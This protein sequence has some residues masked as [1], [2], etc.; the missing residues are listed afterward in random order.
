MFLG[1]AFLILF[2]SVG[3]MQPV[4]AAPAGQAVSGGLVV[5]GAIL[6]LPATPGMV[7]VH[8]MTVGTGNTA[9]A[10]DVTVEAGGF[11][12]D[13]DGSFQEIPPAQDHNPF[14]ALSYIT[15]ISKTSFHLNPG[16]TTEVDVTITLPADPGTKTRYATIYVKGTPIGSSSVTQVLAV[17]VPIIIT[18]QGV[19]FSLTGKITNLTVEPVQP[20]EP[21][22]VD[23][24]VN[25]TGTR[26]FKVQGD[27]TITDPNGQ[28]VTDIKLPLT[29]NSIVPPYS[30]ILTGKYSALDN[31]NGLA[32]GT[33][34]VVVKVT[35]DDGTLVDTAQ[36]TFVIKEPLLICPGVDPS[37]M[38]VQTFT[39]Q[40]PGTVDARNQTNVEV[41]FQNTGPVTGA[42]AI[43]EYSQEPDG[44]PRF[45]DTAE[46]GGT[47]GTGVRFVLIRENGIDQ[48]N[49]QVGISYQQGEL[50]ALDPNS[51]FLATRLGSSWVKLGGLTV[52]TGAQMVTGNLSVDILKN[53]TLIALGGGG[54]GGAG[55]PLWAYG[56]IGLV[57]ALLILLVIL[58]VMSRRRPKEASGS[59]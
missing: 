5:G 4:S 58:L 16:D 33:Y 23:T 48:G 27:V 15:N 59:R 26:H 20:G 19:Q 38:V 47:G 22:V 55:L 14:S 17:L 3:P 52:Q 36:T 13:T 21:I 46:N 2:V 49:A 30:Q 6:D 35:R 43:C 12:Q 45:E 40:E 32:P 24:T 29:G 57:L 44:T 42:V 51:L 9:P 37:H 31:P 11:G 54:R 18:P 56:L 50:G 28:Q 34:T 53:P 1:M 25:N 41:T 10:M 7:Y 39:N 8:K